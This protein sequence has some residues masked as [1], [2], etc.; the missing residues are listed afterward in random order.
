MHQQHGG[1][2]RAHAARHGGICRGLLAGLGGN[3][4]AKLAVHGVYANV[5][6]YAALRHHVRRYHL[7]LSRAGYNYVRIQRM[8][9]KVPRR[10]VAN[11]DRCVFAEQHHPKRLAHNIAAAYYAY[12]FAA[13]VYF[14]ML[15][16]PYHGLRRAWGEAVPPAHKQPRA[17]RVCAVRVLFGRY[18]RA[19]PVRVKVL[20]QG[21][22]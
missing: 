17:Q 22:K 12:V 6:K 15:N 1:C 9:G 18:Q 11:G 4:A 16:K 7:R 19:Q 5:Y 3:V 14:I 8:R 2:K 10:C 21:H 20:R 13:K